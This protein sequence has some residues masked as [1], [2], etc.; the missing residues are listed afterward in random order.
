MSLKNT[1]SRFIVK[2]N[3]NRIEKKSFRVLIQ[4]SLTFLLK[5][6]ENFNDS[7]LR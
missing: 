6:K 5:D 3:P 4:I 7:K 1:L 2:L